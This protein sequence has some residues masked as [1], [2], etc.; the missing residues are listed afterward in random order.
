M[1][2]DVKI[3]LYSGKFDDAEALAGELAAYGVNV[4]YMLKKFKDLDFVFENRLSPENEEKYKYLIGSDDIMLSRELERKG[5][6]GGP[7]I[8]DDTIRVLELL[9]E[10]DRICG[11]LNVDYVAYGPAS[12]IFRNRKFSNMSTALVLMKPGA[13][14]K[15]LDNFN[16]TRPENRDIEYYGNKKILKEVDGTKDMEAVFAD[17]TKLI[18]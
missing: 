7:A 3:A 13:M 5:F 11:D 9:T 8:Q 1:I 15:F 17:I 18:G 12:A 4:D 14:V 10:F 2:H 16:K 6:F